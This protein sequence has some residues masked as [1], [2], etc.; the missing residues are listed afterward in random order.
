MSRKYEESELP[1]RGWKDW[2]MGPSEDTLEFEKSLKEESFQRHINLLEQDMELICKQ[3]KSRSTE[4]NKYNVHLR[5]QLKKHGDWKWSKGKYPKPEYVRK[6]REEFILFY[7]TEFTPTFELLTSAIEEYKSSSG[8]GGRYKN[9]IKV[10]QLC[11][12]KTKDEGQKYIEAFIDLEEK[13]IKEKDKQSKE[14]KNVPTS[15]KRVFGD[16]EQK[17]VNETPKGPKGTKGPKKSK[18]KTSKPKS[19]PKSTPKPKKTIKKTTQASPTLVPSQYFRDQVKKYLK[20]DMTTPVAPK[21]EIKKA[22]QKLSLHIQANSTKYNK[23]PTSEQQ[24]EADEIFKRVTN[25]KEKLCP[26]TSGKGK[27]TKKR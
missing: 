27:K 17:Y 1:V 18:S 23:L 8:G 19:N 5:D 7:E 3:I 14:Q 20:K 12:D 2:L 10:Y 21:A 11:I 26:V 6:A 15:K 4:L 25:E 22:W 9:V 24:A 13:S 16:F